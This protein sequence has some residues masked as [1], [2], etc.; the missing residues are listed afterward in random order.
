MPGSE[1]K[2]KSVKDKTQKK[3]L[4]GVKK[5]FRGWTLCKLLLSIYYI[6]GD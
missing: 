5:I 1:P 4:T 3:K 2:T 6:T